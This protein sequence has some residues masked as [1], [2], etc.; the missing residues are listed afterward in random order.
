MFVSILYTSYGLY[1]EYC[2][3]ITALSLLNFWRDKHFLFVLVITNKMK[4]KLQTYVCKLCNNDVHDKKV[5]LDGHCVKC[6][7]LRLKMSYT[8]SRIEDINKFEAHQQIKKL[9][10][11]E[12]EDTD[13]DDFSNKISGSDDNIK[14]QI[15]WHHQFHLKSKQHQC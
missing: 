12:W 15:L 14:L 3:W 1:F 6:K 10:K 13:E 4:E 9:R 8:A 11:K 2:I 5:Y 7:L